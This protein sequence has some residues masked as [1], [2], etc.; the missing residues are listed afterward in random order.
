MPACAGMTT[1]LGVTN[2]TLAGIVIKKIMA[3]DY[4]KPIINGITKKVKKNPEP[5]RLRVSC[6]NNER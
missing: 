2:S 4:R 5:F 3:V 6:L 1:F